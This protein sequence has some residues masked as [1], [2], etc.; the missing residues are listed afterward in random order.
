MSVSERY[1]LTP[2]DCNRVV[3]DCHLQEVSC[4]DWRLLPCH[5]EVDTAVMR[6]A[7]RSP[8]GEGGKRYEFFLQWKQ[9][10]G[11]EATYVKL[12]G[13]LEKISCKLDAENLCTLLKSS[14]PQQPSQ[15][16]P[17]S[18]PQTCGHEKP[19]S[20]HGEVSW[21]L[22]CQNSSEVKKESVQRRLGNT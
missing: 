13:A 2:S 3:S 14:H 6:D 15:L 18:Q 9:M 1:E 16:Q 7:D 19:G 12:I 17:S 21:D 22:D 20:G 10:K 8:G 4:K 11:S 5:L